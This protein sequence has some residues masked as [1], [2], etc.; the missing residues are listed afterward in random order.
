MEMIIYI[1]RAQHYVKL[2][3]FKFKNFFKLKYLFASDFSHVWEDW[4]TKYANSSLAWISY[5]KE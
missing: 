2:G 3:I 1:L 5:C 4:K